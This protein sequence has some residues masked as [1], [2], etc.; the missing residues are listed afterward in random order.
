M[1][2][3]NKDDHQHFMSYC[4]RSINHIDIHILPFVLK[5][6]CF[7]AFTYILRNAL[8]E[9]KK[10]L[11]YE[12]IL[13]NYWFVISKKTYMKGTIEK[14]KLLLHWKLK[15]TFIL[16]SYYCIENWKWY[17]FWNGMSI[18]VFFFFYI[19]IKAIFLHDTNCW[20]T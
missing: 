2:E 10:I 1:K 19:L 18:Y 13:I 14:K 9:E 3:E 16:K 15:V 8:I 20:L 11:F 12:I 7:K 17:S 5:W 6:M 4:G